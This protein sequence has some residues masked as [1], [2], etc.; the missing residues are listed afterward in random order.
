MASMPSKR[1]RGAPA[2][3]SLDELFFTHPRLVIEELRE[4]DEALRRLPQSSTTPLVRLLHDAP[5]GLRLA[6]SGVSTSTSSSEASRRSPEGRGQNGE[7]DDGDEA[8]EW[9]DA[10]SDDDDGA[11][12]AFAGDVAAWSG[13]RGCE[14]MKEIIR[15]ITRPPRPLFALSSLTRLRLP[16]RVLARHRSAAWAPRGRLRRHRSCIPRLRRQLQSVV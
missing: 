6:S 4:L 13:G 7:G 12:E 3:Y 8:E 5:F 14:K 2:W 1:R 11:R 16:C 9:S 15:I 10:D